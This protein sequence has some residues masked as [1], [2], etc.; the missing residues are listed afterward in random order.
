MAKRAARRAITPAATQRIVMAS[1][2]K[3]ATDVPLITTIK[4]SRV[5][6]VMKW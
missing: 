5:M 4:R 6:V 3:D 2:E 1:K